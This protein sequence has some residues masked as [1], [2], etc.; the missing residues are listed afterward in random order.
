MQN[1]LYFR[2]TIRLSS[3]KAGFFHIFFSRIRIFV[4]R[5]DG[6]NVASLLPTMHSAPAILYRSMHLTS[7]KLYS[8]HFLQFSAAA[9][10][11]SWKVSGVFLSF[12]FCSKRVFAASAQLTTE[13]LSAGYRIMAMCCCVPQLYTGRKDRLNGLR[14]P[15]ETGEQSSQQQ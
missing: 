14:R 4:S 12:L 6:N 9:I 13:D 7:F 8:I 10:V 11:S 15:L 5:H 1:G 2:P 3:N